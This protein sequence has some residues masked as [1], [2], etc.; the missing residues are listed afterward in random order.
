MFD[1][2]RLSTLHPALVHL[3]LG[4][5]PLVLVAYAIAASQHSGRW[6]FAGDVALG[7]ASISALLA[8]ALGYIAY[9][10]VQWPGGLAPWP[11][12]HL[13]GGTTT[14]LG[15]WIMAALRWRSVQRDIRSTA[16]PQSPKPHRLRWA[17]GALG[18]TV[19]VLATGYIGGEVLVFHAGIGVKAASLGALAP[20]LSAA[21]DAPQSLHDSMH[22]VRAHWAR[23]VGSIARS[24]VHEPS[25]TEFEAIAEDARRIE[26]LARWLVDWGHQGTHGHADPDVMR[27]HAGT[28]QRAAQQLEAAATQRD[29][30]DTIDALGAMT[31]GCAECH[32]D[33]RWSTAEPDQRAVG[34]GPA[35]ARAHGAAVP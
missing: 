27:E 25:A 35:E 32:L 8:A 14:T 9:F 19:L 4:V 28:L 11:L 10:S 26:R 23:S 18:L 12:A 22:R 30:A 16:G 31:R 29:L 15:L 6:M 5:I 3:P 34:G 13:I 20:P 7:F 21:V 24:V 1:L 33:Q 2:I 17:I